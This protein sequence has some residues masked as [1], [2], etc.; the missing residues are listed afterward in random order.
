MTS[1]LKSGIICS[2]STHENGSRFFLNVLE[3]VRDGFPYVAASAQAAPGEPDQAYKLIAGVDWDKIVGARILHAI[4]KERLDI[5]G[6]LIQDR[7]GCGEGLPSLQVKQRFGRACRAG[8]VRHDRLG[9]RASIDKGHIDRD[10]Q[11]VPLLVRHLETFQCQ[12]APWNKR[13]LP[14]TRSLLAEEQ[15]ASLADAHQL[16]VG[17]I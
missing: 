4:D 15:R 13:V 12:V 16:A 1:K 2:F 7:V 6:K 9:A 5:G 3:V 17:E 8:V 14:G 10:G 11:V